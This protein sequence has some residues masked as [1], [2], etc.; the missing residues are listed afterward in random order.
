MPGLCHTANRGGAFCYD[1]LV[2]GNDGK[3]AVVSTVA[4]L[5][6]L[7]AALS[8]CLP[9]GTL[10]MSAG[11]AGASLFSERLRPWLLAFSFASLVFAFVQTYFRRR[12]EFRHR[13][14]RTVLLWFSAVMV[15]GMLAAPRAMSTLF[16]G[17]IPSFSPASRLSD[18]DQREFE[19]QFNAAANQT[20]L[21]VL[22][23]PT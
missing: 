8:C 11:S 14:L 15:V 16:A 19:R 17:R 6:S 23:S 7:L 13:R 5:A 12:C 1:S 2:A 9:L 3:S 20:R 10:L 4:S 21:V 22:L 18:F